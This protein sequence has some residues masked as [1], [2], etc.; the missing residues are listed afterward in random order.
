[1]ISLENVMEPGFFH[2]SLHMAA[3]FLYRLGS[4]VFGDE[5]EEYGRSGRV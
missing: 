4:Q 2:R 3:V 1:M 5:R